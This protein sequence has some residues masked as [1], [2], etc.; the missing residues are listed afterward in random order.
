MSSLDLTLPVGVIGG[1]FI[2]YAARRWVSSRRALPLPPGPKPLPIIGNIHQFPDENEHLTF[3]EWGKAYGDIIYVNLLGQPVVI[4]NSA[5]AAIDLFEKRSDIY[6]ERPVLT[7]GGE[8]AGWD[9][10]LAY[11]THGE[12]FRQMRKYLSQAMNP[13]AVKGYRPLQTSEA[14]ASCARQLTTPRD[15]IRHIDR[16]VSAL[17]LSIIYGYCVSADGD[18]LVVRIE[19]LSESFSRT[20]HAGAYLV[21]IFPSLKYVPA[22]LPGAGFKRQAARWKKSL[23]DTLDDAFAM[24]HSRMAAGTQTPSLASHL[25]STMSDK[26]EEETI[27]WTVLSVHAGGTDPSIAALKTFYLAMTLYPA[28]Q[29]KARAEIDGVTGGTR[30]PEFQ[31][32]EDLPYVKAIIKEVLRW[33]SVANTVPHASKREDVYEGYRIPKGSIV[34]AN[35]WTMHN[36]PAVFK[37]ARTFQPER[38]LEADGKTPVVVPY[39]KEWGSFVFG[40][41]R[42]I[43]PGQALADDTLFINVA[44][45]LATLSISKA[46]NEHGAPIEPDLNHIPGAISH[47]KP[48]ACKIEPRSSEAAELPKQAAETATA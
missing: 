44:T 16:T 37:D 10:S 48:F 43:C 28:V 8:L 1:I 42:R 7:M 45:T 5:K 24:V 41:R 40:F 17:A 29:K 34:F 33:N 18:P 47:P 46:L 38:F 9:R 11:T 30:L 23:L 32:R 2:V 4:L 36:N 31:D 13:R 14:R 39:A 19:E 21:N 20:V 3:E 6:S 12:R 15:F 35:F 22:W 27:R 26:G 25:L